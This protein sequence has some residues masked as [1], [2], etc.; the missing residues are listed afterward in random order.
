[1]NMADQV[2]T[3]WIYPPNFDG[4]FPVD[5]PCG[6]KRYTVNFGCFSDGT[7]EEDVTKIRR[8]DLLSIEGTVPKSL[9][10]EKIEYDVSG[11]TVL[12]DWSSNTDDRIAVLNAS[13]G[14][15][16]FAALGGLHIN[17]TNP[18]DDPEWGSIIFN[19][20]TDTFGSSD[21]DEPLDAPDP[22]SSYN[23]TFTVRAKS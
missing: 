5:T 15:M 7:G 9:V 18:G 10:I 12:I 16:D 8:S 1:M 11:M 17:D 2:N 3:K 20:T 22:G 13:T 6:H 19:T 4:T 14:I 21:I 23:I